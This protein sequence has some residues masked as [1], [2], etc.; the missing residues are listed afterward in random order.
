MTLTVR[1]EGTTAQISENGHNSEWSLKIEDEQ[2]EY[3]IE[4][5]QQV[6][7]E[8]ETS[9]LSNSII[10]LKSSNLKNVFYVMS[11]GTMIVEFKS[12]SKYGYSDVPPKIFLELLRAKSHGEY[13]NS[14]FT[15]GPYKYEKL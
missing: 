9:T 10:P 7:D 1:R 13:F 2:L 5:L 4:R 14:K 12:G 3:V 6:K 11:T 15:K 8:I